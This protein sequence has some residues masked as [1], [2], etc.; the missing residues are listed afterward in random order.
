MQTNI[1]L[2]ANPDGLKTGMIIKD[3][4]NIRSY[5]GSGHAEFADK[6]IQR[7]INVTE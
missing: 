4:V 7:R 2:I 6:L 3:A 5:R 1:A